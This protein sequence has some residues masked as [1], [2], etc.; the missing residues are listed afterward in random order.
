MAGR[1]S[2]RKTAVAGVAV[3]LEARVN[4][5][6]FVVP[7]NPSHSPIPTMSRV[8]FTV[9]GTISLILA[10]V[11]IV[12]PLLPTTPF[13]LLSA[14]CFAR[15][16]NRF[17]RMLMEHPVLGGTIRTFQSGGG[18]P[19]GAKIRAIALVWISISISAFLVGGGIW[20]RVALFTI[21]IG[22]TVY[23]VRLPTSEKPTPLDP[24]RDEER[25][26]RSSSEGGEKG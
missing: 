20:L 4:P 10:I 18:I 9:V 19:R 11:G 17:H 6:S 7:E 26:V 23:L 5:G 25:G 21:A 12:L 13:L 15:S 14:A 8:F 22:V 16:S 3:A 1:R 24:A 2:G